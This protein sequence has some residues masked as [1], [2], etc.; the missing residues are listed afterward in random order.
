M[1]KAR[2]VLW[3][4]PEQCQLY[5]GALRDADIELVGAGSPDPA[6]TG[7]VASDLST[8]PIDDLRVAMSSTQADLL[9]LASP[10]SFG[11]QA[12][13]ADLDALK[14]A[15]ERNLIVTTL[16]PIPAIVSGIAGTSFAHALSTGALDE[17]ARMTPLTR[18]TPMIDE[19]CTVLETFAPVRSCAI[20]IAAPGAMGTLGAR[21]FDA[22]D[23]V[24]SLIGIPN[25]IDA[26][27]ASPAAGRGMHPLPGQ[28]LRDL[29]GEFTLNLRFSDGRCATVLLSDQVARSTISINMLSGE[30]HLI[31]DNSGFKWFN[32]SGEVIDSYTAP[33]TEDLSVDPSTRA[34]IAQLIEHTTGVGPK[35]PPIDYPAVLSMS[36]A[37]LLSTRTGQG[38][39]PRAV[40]QLLLSL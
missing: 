23:L 27:Y 24:R 17:L 40:E 16:E 14:A 1:S 8:E 34:L 18:S 20:T 37:S 13:D 25:I 15:H 12:Q 35:R 33:E 26:S 10:G 3:I 32:P 22:M 39:S 30:G 6:R 29:H 31:A 7:Q 36:H 5:A 19:L 11:D 21:L 38:E 4:N 28:S 2:C 9:V